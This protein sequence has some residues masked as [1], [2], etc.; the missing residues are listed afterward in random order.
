MQTRMFPDLILYFPDWMQTKSRQ[1]Y[2]P[3]QNLLCLF[4]S[5]QSQGVLGGI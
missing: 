3:G 5:F 4:H 1:S 2:L